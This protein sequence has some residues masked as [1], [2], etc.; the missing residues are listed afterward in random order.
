MGPRQSGKTT[1]AKKVFPEYDYVSFEQPNIRSQVRM[2][3][4]GF[5]RGLQKNAIIDE[6]QR[7]PEILSYLQGIL[8]DDTDQRRFILTGSNS[9]LLSSQVAQSLAGRT[10]LVY[11]LPLQYSEIPKAEKASDLSGTLFFGSYPRIFKEKLRPLE[12]YGDYYQTYVEK[13]LRSL[14]QIE[15]LNSF[16]RFIRLAA[17][18][19]GQLLNYA[20]LAGDAGISQPTAKKWLSVLEASFIVFTLAPHFRNF[21]KRMIKSPKLYFYD[22]G[23]LAYL[24]RIQEPSQIDNHPLRGAIFENWVIVDYLKNFFNQG[25]EAPLYFWRD[26]H[27]HEVDLVIDKGAKL[28]LIEI[29]SGQTF[30]PEFLDQISWLGGLQKTH[31]GTLIYGGEESFSFQDHSIRSW[32]SL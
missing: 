15:N 13:D 18:R 25:K 1:L 28:D 22:T 26:Q 12:W 3:P 16:D 4:L 6:V 2:D 20:Q 10:R 9:L 31:G 8:D 11:V 27:G 19:C 5:L 17:G 7:V 21:S 29:K 14:I 24:L 32:R 30:H 23:L